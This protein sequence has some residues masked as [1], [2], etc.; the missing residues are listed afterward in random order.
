[1]DIRRLNEAPVGFRYH[2]TRG[3]PIMS[4]D[5]EVR[6][7]WLERIRDEYGDFQP[8]ARRHLAELLR[9]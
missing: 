2:A 1:M 3:L 4:R 5:D 9:E 7:T 6:D 8:V